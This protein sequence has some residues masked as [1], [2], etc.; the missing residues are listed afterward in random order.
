MQELK[1][2]HRK[3]RGAAM[4]VAWVMKYIAELGAALNAVEAE[5]QRAPRKW[6]PKNLKGPETPTVIGGRS[7]KMTRTQKVVQRGQVLEVNRPIR[8]ATEDAPRQID[9]VL[10]R[11]PRGQTPMDIQVLRFLMDILGVTILVNPPIYACL[12]DNM[13]VWSEAQA[14]GVPPRRAAMVWR[15]RPRGFKTEGV[16]THIGGEGQEEPW[17]E[18]LP[19]A[20]KVFEYPIKCLTHEKCPGLGYTGGVRV[21]LT[22]GTPVPYE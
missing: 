22:H 14:M 18:F 17:L 4:V 20:V 6:E 16:V 5:W 12:D 13:E 15:T 1:R 2:G 9:L 3:V 8:T 21:T 7:A 19:E 11:Q 10:C